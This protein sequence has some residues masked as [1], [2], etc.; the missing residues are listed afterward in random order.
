ML[1]AAISDSEEIE[2]RGIKR[3]EFIKLPKTTITS[4]DVL[5]IKLAVQR[6]KANTIKSLA[7]SKRKSVVTV[8]KIPSS[9]N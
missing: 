5:D 2:E 4:D 9:K 6:M 7:A 8:S 1:A 3:G